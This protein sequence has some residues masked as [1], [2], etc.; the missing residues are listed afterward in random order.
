M[1]YIILASSNKAGRNN[2]QID[3]QS[4]LGEIGRCTIDE[5][6]QLFLNLVD[7]V[8]ELNMEHPRCTPVTIVRSRKTH[9]HFEERSKV[10]SVFSSVVL[11]EI[12]KPLELNP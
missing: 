1:K 4:H 7:K 3:I 5:P 8:E 12:G 11:V 2:L 6:D 10:D 9:F